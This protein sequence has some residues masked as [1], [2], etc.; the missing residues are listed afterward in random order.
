MNLE[1]SARR[2]SLA[3]VG[4]GAAITVVAGCAGTKVATRPVPSGGVF[5]QLDELRSVNGR[6]AVTLTAE[7]TMV[8]FGTAQGSPADR[9]G[10]VP[11]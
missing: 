6:L 10:C 1:R 2:E 9:A 7:A 8:P 11:R 4:S 5:V 3:L